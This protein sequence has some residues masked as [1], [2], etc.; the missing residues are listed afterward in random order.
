[1]TRLLSP[2]LDSW[3]RRVLSIDQASVGA[4]SLIPSTITSQEQEVFDA[5]LRTKLRRPAVGNELKET[6]DTPYQGSGY[7]EQ[8]KKT[9]FT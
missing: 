3:L 8:E 2:V 7:K 6:A 1:M 4:D 5:T 9:N